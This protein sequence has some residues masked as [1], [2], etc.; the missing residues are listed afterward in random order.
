MLNLWGHFSSG[1]STLFCV[2]VEEILSE[3]RQW[4][5]PGVRGHG[6]GLAEGLITP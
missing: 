1:G 4:V 6:Q 3:R 2:S 5:V